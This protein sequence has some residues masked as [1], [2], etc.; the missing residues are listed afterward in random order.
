M[1]DSMRKSYSLMAI[2][3]EWK[4]ERQVRRDAIDGHNLPPPSAASKGYPMFP[5]RTLTEIDRLIMRVRSRLHEVSAPTVI[6]QAREDDMTSPRNASIVY[7]E[8]SSMVK[9]LVL[10]DD[11]Y[12]VITIDKKREAVAE[13]VAAFFQFQTVKILA[14]QEMQVGS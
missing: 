9:Q 5:L 4:N 7:D 10:L 14:H 6:L 13:N 1:Q 8:I 11:C 12:H 2:L 3:H